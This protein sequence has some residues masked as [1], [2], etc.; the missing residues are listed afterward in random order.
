MIVDFPIHF[1]LYYKEQKSNGIYS[2]SPRFYTP[3]L[4]RFEQSILNE[5]VSL[6]LLYSSCLSSDT[7]VSP[8]IASTAFYMRHALLGPM[9]VT[10]ALALPL[11]LGEKYRIQ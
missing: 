3:P 5:V 10:S 8:T 9:L 6:I 2:L 4:N 1:L 11:F 7:P